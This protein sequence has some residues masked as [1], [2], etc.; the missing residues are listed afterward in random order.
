MRVIGVQEKTATR[1][2]VMCPAVLWYELEGGLNL[3]LGFPEEWVCAK[4]PRRLR[5]INSET[6]SFEV[7][8]S[9]FVQKH[10]VSLPNF[11]ALFPNYFRIATR[12]GLEGPGFE[13]RWLWDF[14]HPS[15]PTP[16]PTQPRVK[17]V[18]GLPRRKIFGG[19]ALIIHPNLAPM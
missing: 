14:P 13:I 10:Y 8:G 2:A 3:L 12:F 11:M 16:R 6:R 9:R 18:L 15:I 19:V 7:E 1:V 5:F 4:V 17:W